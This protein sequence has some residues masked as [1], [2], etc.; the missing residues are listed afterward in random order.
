MN[1]MD[2]CPRYPD[3]L[4]RLHIISLDKQERMRRRIGGAWVGKCR[5]CGAEV[6]VNA[7]AWKAFMREL[8]DARR[9]SW[10]ADRDRQQPSLF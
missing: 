8:R 4:G 10:R 2:R 3:C 9:N 7:R 6:L 1:L 5:A